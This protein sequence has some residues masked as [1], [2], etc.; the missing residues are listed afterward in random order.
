MA[1]D[2]GGGRGGMK[3]GKLKIGKLVRG[4][5][6]GAAVLFVLLMGVGAVSIGPAPALGPLLDPAHGVWA[7]ARSAEL[8]NDANAVVST[9]GSTVEV[10]Y[11][12]RGVP[13]IF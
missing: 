7:L 10:R 13:H 5:L 2:E 11:D 9:L 6:L 4:R 3:L 12:R 8:P 1:H